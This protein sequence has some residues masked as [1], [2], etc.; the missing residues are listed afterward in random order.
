MATFNRMRL[1]R[2]LQSV[3]HARRTAATKEAA[4]SATINA[5]ARRPRRALLYLP[6]MDERKVQ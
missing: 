3:A 4:T 5:V 6:G 2:V 1:S